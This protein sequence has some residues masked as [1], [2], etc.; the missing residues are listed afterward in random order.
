MPAWMQGLNNSSGR[1]SPGT[2]ED[3]TWRAQ[4]QP[5]PGRGIPCRRQGHVTRAPSKSLQSQE[6]AT[7][8]NA[9]LAV[10]LGC[11][12]GLS[13]PAGGLWRLQWRGVLGAGSTAIHSG[14]AHRGDR[15]HCR[16]LNIGIR[17]P[18]TKDLSPLE[19]QDPESSCRMKRD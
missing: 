2:G 11:G 16:E 7:A 17:A 19:G 18:Q 13:A 8:H 3:P 1:A 6:R 4:N 10:L 12:W 15:G 14:Q 9:R 5:I